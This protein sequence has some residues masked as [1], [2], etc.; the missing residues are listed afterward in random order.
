MVSLGIWTRPLDAL[1]TGNRVWLRLQQLVGMV[2]NQ[3]SITW[4]VRQKRFCFSVCHYG[5]YLTCGLFD[6]RIQVLSLR[7]VKDIQSSTMSSVFCSC[8]AASHLFYLSRARNECHT[9]MI[10]A[11]RY[12]AADD[13]CLLSYDL[14][15]IVPPCVQQ[16][17]L[18]NQTSR[19]MKS[20][21]FESFVS[22]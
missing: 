17:M 14:C 22:W 20:H 2:S 12:Y 7:P 19:M 4:S 16:V 11:E 9:R 5:M 18:V 8:T 3:G 10:R 15:M 6:P 1:E 21:S 13:V